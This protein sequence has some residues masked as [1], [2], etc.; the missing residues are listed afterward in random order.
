ME[1]MA[2]QSIFR[3]LM[4]RLPLVLIALLVSGCFGGTKQTT[5][6]PR[7]DSTQIIHELY[8]LVTWIDVGI[9]FV[10]FV[11]LLYALWRFRDKGT[12]EIPKQV[13]GNLILEITWTLVPA[14]LLLFIAVPTWVGIFRAYS[15]PT[16]NAY[17]V[18]AIGHQWWWE[19]KYPDTVACLPTSL[20]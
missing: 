6:D 20:R 19:F 13:H 15:P 8:A 18:Q 5:V 3:R 12:G 2:D 14:I 9:F 7:S 16:E 10:V 1:N 17:T 11:P 4:A